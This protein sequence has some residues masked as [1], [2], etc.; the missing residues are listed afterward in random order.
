MLSLIQK[1]FRHKKAQKTQ[2][3]LSGSFVISVLCY[4]KSPLGKG[5]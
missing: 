3:K 4:G 1:G 2:K 5:G